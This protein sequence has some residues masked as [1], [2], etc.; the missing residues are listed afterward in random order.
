M[1]T[2]EDEEEGDNEATFSGFA[3]L[4][5][6][7][8]CPSASVDSPLQSGA[9]QCR[10]AFIRAHSNPIS[11]LELSPTQSILVSCEGMI[12]ILFTFYV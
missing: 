10:Q 9:K 12:Y 6:S 5:K 4:F 7:L 11:L 8:P 2:G 1:K 3:R